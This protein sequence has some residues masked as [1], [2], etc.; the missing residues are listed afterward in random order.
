MTGDSLH[1]TGLGLHPALALPH[2]SFLVWHQT[3]TWKTSSLG[4]A[5]PHYGVQAGPKLMQPLSCLSLPSTVLPATLQQYCI[6]S[7]TFASCR[8][9]P[10]YMQSPALLCT[11]LLPV[12]YLVPTTGVTN[13]NTLSHRGSVCAHPSPS[14]T[15]P[16]GAPL[17]GLLLPCPSDLAP[18]I[19][20]VTAATVGLGRLVLQA[21]VNSATPTIPGHPLSPF[22]REQLPP[23][24][25][26]KLRC[27]FRMHQGSR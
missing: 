10:T 24:K 23:P 19:Q 12:G 16:T 11:P 17:S 21:Q 4:S 27:I 2:T 26:H 6:S 18:Q 5:V 9:A 8:N 15:S 25:Q 13:P 22:H 20:Q 14:P 3:I 7:T 1:V